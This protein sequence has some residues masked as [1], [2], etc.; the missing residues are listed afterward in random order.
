MKEIVYLLLN[1]LLVEAFLVGIWTSL[2]YIGLHPFLHGYTLWFFL[3]F[4]KHGFSG[5]LG[6]H[7]VYCRMKGASGATHKTL[8]LDSV[9]EGILFAMGHFFIK[10]VWYAAFFMGSVLHLLFEVTGIHAYFIK[11]RCKK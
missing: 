8:L 6:L 3:G 1:M 11:T 2:L 7:D 9:G 10:D 4:L 5:I